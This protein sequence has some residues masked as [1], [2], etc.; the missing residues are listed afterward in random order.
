M[1]FTAC[2]KEETNQPIQSQTF[3]INSTASTVWKYFS[4]AKN[5]TITV[6]DPATSTDMGSG[7]SALPDQNQ[8]RKIRQ[9]NR[10][11]QQ[12]LIRKGRQDLML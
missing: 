1:S 9:W 5:D 2:K 4:F 3:E 11:V 8:W 6:T 12:T 7:F 10:A